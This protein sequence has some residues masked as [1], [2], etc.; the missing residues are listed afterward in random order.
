MFNVYHQY[1]IFGKNASFGFSLKALRQYSQPLM[2][3]MIPPCYTGFR[4]TS[5]ILQHEVDATR[6]SVTYPV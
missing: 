4:C 5:I 1:M 2:A 6:P 3:S